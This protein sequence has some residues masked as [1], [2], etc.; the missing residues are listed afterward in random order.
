MLRAKLTVDRISTGPVRLREGT[1]E[2]LHTEC[3]VGNG[4]STTTFVLKP[5]TIERSGIQCCNNA[6]TV[7]GALHTPGDIAEEKLDWIKWATRLFFPMP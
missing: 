6:A 3:F 1:Q 4:S 7:V 5:S 2:F